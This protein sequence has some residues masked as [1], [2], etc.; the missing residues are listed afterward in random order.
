MYRPISLGPVAKPALA[1]DLLPSPAALDLRLLHHF[2]RSNRQIQCMVVPPARAAK[3]LAFSPVTVTKNH[4]GH[5][6]NCNG[7]LHD[8]SYKKQTPFKDNLPE[9]LP[10][11]K[12]LI[13]RVTKGTFI[14]WLNFSISRTHLYNRE[15]NPSFIVIC[16]LIN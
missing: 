9:N 4:D 2:C 14:S 13:I 10:K 16:K 3:P 8:V 15:N 11:T 7:D 1:C 5:F 12:L 6:A